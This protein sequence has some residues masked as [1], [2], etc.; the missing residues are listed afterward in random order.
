MTETRNTEWTCP[1]FTLNPLTFQIVSF[2]SSNL[3][4]FYK[5]FT[6][7]VILIPFLSETLNKNQPNTHKTKT[8]SSKSCA[9]EDA[10]MHS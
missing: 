7:I 1:V 4:L 9:R 8:L 2:L 3:D 10:S 6:L 5:P